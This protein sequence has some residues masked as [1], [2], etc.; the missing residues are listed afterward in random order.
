MGPRQQGGLHAYCPREVILVPLLARVSA[1]AP[2][3]SPCLSPVGRQVPVC[4]LRCV[5]VGTRPSPP[6]LGPFWNV[7]LPFCADH[8]RSQQTP[9]TPVVKAYPKAAPGATDE[10]TAG[11]VGARFG[12]GYRVCSSFEIGLLIFR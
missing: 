4:P 2:L 9:A 7:P 10:T 12:Q 8:L 5:R 3:V 6:A 1:V 11:I